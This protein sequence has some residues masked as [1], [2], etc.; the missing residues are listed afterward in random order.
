MAPLY[1]RSS[2]L[3]SI[4]SEAGLATVGYFNTDFG[5]QA[6][7]SARLLSSL[8]IQLCIQSDNF[9]E[10]P[11]SLYSTHDRR[12]QQS[13]ENRKHFLVKAHSTPMWMVWMNIRMPVALRHH[14]NKLSRL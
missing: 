1:P 4:S 11:H 14:V 12:L 2:Y 3:S 9:C 5:D 7:R 8:L 10:I 6:K 13:S